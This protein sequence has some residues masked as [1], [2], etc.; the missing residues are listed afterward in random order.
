MS[1]SP[2]SHDGDI[3]RRLLELR[4]KMNKAKQLNNQAVIAE[5]KHIGD[6]Q[7]LESNETAVAS[8][9]RQFREGGELGGFYPD[10]YN[11]Q[12]EE[13]G[14]SRF[15]EPSG[16]VVHKPSEE[17]KIRLV[18][19]LKKE[20]QRRGKFS[21]KRLHDDDARDVEWINERNK[22]YTK[23]LDKSYGQYTADIKSSIDRGTAI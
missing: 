1:E 18:D 4:L 7:K 8:G 19:S 21:R 15:Y 6:H 12:K 16:V 11:K 23:K 13:V 17:A 14:E 22:D 10:S 2:P 5:K 9:R 3:E 20:Q